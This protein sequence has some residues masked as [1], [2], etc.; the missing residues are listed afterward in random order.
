MIKPELKR[1]KLNCIQ[2]RTVYN[3]QVC[4]HPAHNMPAIFPLKFNTEY[5]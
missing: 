3:L 2:T 4:G 1:L 5:I